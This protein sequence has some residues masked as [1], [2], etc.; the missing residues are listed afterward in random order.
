MFVGGFLRCG[1]GTLRYR[2]QRQ[3]EGLWN[4]QA[5][6]IMVLASLK[7]CVSL[8]SEGQVPAGWRARTGHWWS[9]EPCELTAL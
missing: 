9:G 6:N 3:Q 4:R 2:E 1:A 7:D 5:R 8:R